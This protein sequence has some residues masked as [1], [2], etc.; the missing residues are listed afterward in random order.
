[1]CFSDLHLCTSNQTIKMKLRSGK[2]INGKVIDG[3]NFT[4]NPPGKNWIMQ[5]TS[6]LKESHAS[7]GIERISVIQEIY[8]I[9]YDN[10]ETI[11]SD[12]AYKRLMTTMLQKSSEHIA[13]LNLLF[14]EMIQ[15]TSYN[16]LNKTRATSLDTYA[17]C[18]AEILRV[19]TYFESK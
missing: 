13:S 14:S 18:M 9:I 8:T 3:N 17:N 1:M 12:P 4:Q 7:S 2:V 11:K 15:N 10:K 19:R 16:K 6:L 5:L